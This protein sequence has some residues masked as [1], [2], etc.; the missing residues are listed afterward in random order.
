M[1]PIRF[2]LVFSSTVLKRT[3][4]KV[5]FGESD[6]RRVAK[7]ELC[8]SC[9][10]IIT[11]DE[12]TIENSLD[13]KGYNSPNP[14]FYFGLNLSILQRLEQEGCSKCINLFRQVTR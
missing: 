13:S 11:H 14:F 2:Q 4:N 7:Y 5:P 1:E 10:K 6:M 12:S 8:N 9:R 3:F